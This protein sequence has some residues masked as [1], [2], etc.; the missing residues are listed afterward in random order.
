MGILD[1]IQAIII[2]GAVIAAAYYVTKLVA[3]TRGGVYQRCS[4]LRLI[5]SLPLAKDKAVALVAI[6]EHVYVLGVGSQRVEQLDKLE[7]SELNLS[8]PVREPLQQDFTAI[9]QK[10]LNARLKKLRK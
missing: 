2:L 3:K 10:E 7:L 9:F 5:G 6:G 1:V 4:D 8:E